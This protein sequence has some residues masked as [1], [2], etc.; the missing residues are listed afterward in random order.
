MKTDTAQECQE[1]CA[2]V[3]DC[4]EFTWIGIALGDDDDATNKCCLKN[5]AYDNKQSSP[6]L[7]SGPKNC[8]RLK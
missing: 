1:E 7:V 5:A 8:G 6:G 4:V 2:K 3:D